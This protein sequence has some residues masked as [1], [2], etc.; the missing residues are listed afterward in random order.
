MKSFS[1]SIYGNLILDRIV[2]LEKFPQEGIA[3]NVNNISLR[4]G[5]AANVAA[6]YHKLTGFKPE[7][8]SAVGDDFDGTA[9]VEM[10]DEYCASF[11]EKIHGSAT[12]TAVILDSVNCATRTGL[13]RWGACVEMQNFIESSSQWKHFCYI[14]KLNKINERS[15]KSL[16][17]IK[18]VDLTSFDYGDL[19]RARIMSCFSEI[20][21]VVTAKEEAGYLVKSDDIEEISM[22]IGKACKSYVILHHPR[23]SYFCDGNDLVHVEAEHKDLTNVSVIG[24][25]DIF[26]A[27]FIVN[28]HSR[29]TLRDILIKSHNSTYEILRERK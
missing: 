7:L 25:G 6:A 26:L 10:L 17:G 20:D 2:G 28:H 8:F 24:A 3:Q 4:A 27:S 16:S 29:L 13:V 1:L 14:D 18:S 11:I 12:S 5:A 15:L 9:C 22:K 23:G 19:D 21:Y